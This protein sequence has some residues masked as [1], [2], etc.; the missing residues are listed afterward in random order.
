VKNEVVQRVKEEWNFL[1]RRKR[2]K[3]N[4]ISHNLRGNCF[5]KHVTEGKIDETED[6]EDD[7]SSY[8]I[9]LRKK[10]GTGN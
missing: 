9:T 10:G 6:E 4:W 8:W 5:L 7:I 2:N 1:Y 3:A